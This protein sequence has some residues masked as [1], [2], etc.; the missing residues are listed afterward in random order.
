MLKIYMIIPSIIILLMGN[1]FLIL[2][3]MNY[4]FSDFA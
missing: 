1:I 2:N 3:L 4:L